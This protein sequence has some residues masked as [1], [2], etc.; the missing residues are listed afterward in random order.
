VVLEGT[1]GHSYL[2]Y[3]EHFAPFQAE[4]RELRDM[5]PEPWRKMFRDGNFNQVLGASSQVWARLIDHDVSRGFY[6]DGES[7]LESHLTN[8]SLL[9]WALGGLSGGGPGDEQIGRSRLLRVIACR[10]LTGDLYPGRNLVAGELVLTGRDACADTGGI[11]HP[12]DAAQWPL[13]V[14][15]VYFQGEHDP[16]TPLAQARY[17]FEAQSHVP[18]WFI[19]IDRAGHSVLNITLAV[20]DCRERLWNAIASNLDRLEAASR[21]CDA[22]LQHAHVSVSYRP[23]ETETAR[24]STAV[25]AVGPAM[26]GAEALAEELGDD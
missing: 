4:W 17:H 22:L 14:P 10:E 25:P 5:L 2:N 18:R 23:A 3:A 1:L 16:A 9:F 11:V 8:S 26:P 24:A 20:G 12:Y 13:S 19:S 21:A 15:V 6:P 7:L